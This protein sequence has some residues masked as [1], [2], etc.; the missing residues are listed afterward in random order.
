MS[1]LKAF[2]TISIITSATIFS[3]ATAQSTSKISPYGDIRMIY[4]GSSTDAHGL[5]GRAPFLRIRA[6]LNF[7]INTN[8]SFAARMAYIVSRDV[9]SPDFSFTANRGLVPDTFSFDEFYYKYQDEKQQLKLGRFQKSFSLPT[10]TGN[11]ITRY[12][13]SSTSIHWSDG[14]FYQRALNEGWYSE[15]VLEYQKRGEL[16]FSY[17][18]ALN[19]A[20]NEHNFIGYLGIINKQR[21]QYNIIEKGF[22]LMWAPD[23]FFHNGE[24]TSYLTIS[25]SIVFDFPKKELL[26]NGSFRVTGELGQN[27][28]T[29]FSD[30]SV[31]STSFGVYDVDNR[32]TLMIELSRNDRDWLTAPY[33]INSDIFELRYSLSITSKLTMD[34][35][36]KISSYRSTGVDNTYSSFIRATYV[37]GK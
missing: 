37:F 20:K 3:A 24:Y 15:L 16:S 31:L 17:K 29:K 19:F 36:Y 11:S 4:S 1:F 25:S 8:H 35:R 22:A 12:Q 21:D 27:L 5:G 34:A 6:G 28:S 32:H 14:L 2:L 13:S 30:G 9:N 33:P 18:P 7:D 10:A 23:A 26:N